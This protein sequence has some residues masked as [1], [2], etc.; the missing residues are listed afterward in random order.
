MNVDWDYDCSVRG[1]L[2]GGGF[3]PLSDGDVRRIHEA[4]L[5][6][7]ERTGIEVMP[8]ECREIFRTAGATIDEAR[9]R[10]FI[11]RS[12]VDD[13]LASARNKVFLCGRNPEHDMT[14]GGTRVYMGTGGAAVKIFE[15]ETRDCSTRRREGFSMLSRTSTS[16]FG[17]AWD[18]ISLQS[19][20]ISTRTTPQ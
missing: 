2:P 20:S 15:P 4:S 13:A 11:P 6:V 19:T 10:V 5:E 9:N 8:S 17:L 1:G 3:K 14:L 7:L 18:A 12:M 16:T